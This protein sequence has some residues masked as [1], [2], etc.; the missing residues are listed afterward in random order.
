L[1]E[2]AD[3]LILRTNAV[4]AE[5]ESSDAM[6][7]RYRLD[8]DLVVGTVAYMF[9]E[10]V[11]QHVFNRRTRNKVW[12]TEF[13][14]MTKFFDVE[15]FHTMELVQQKRL[16]F[17]CSLLNGNAA[18]NGVKVEDVVWALERSTV[19]IHV[20][21][22]ADEDKLQYIHTFGK[23]FTFRPEDSADKLLLERMRKGLR[24]HLE[25]EILRAEV[26]EFKRE[27]RKRFPNE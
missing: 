12:E 16:L 17:Y 20:P 5:K 13:Q 25:R 19:P 14:N 2:H 10:D 21:A 6:W 9:R 26:A 8:R 4:K 11:M 22:R 3:K 1:E 7:Q 18:M 23:E 27:R 24:R 15:T